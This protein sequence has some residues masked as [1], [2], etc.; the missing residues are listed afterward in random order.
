MENHLHHQFFSK[1]VTTTSC[2]HVI[3]AGL[4]SHQRG[5]SLLTLYAMQRLLKEACIN[6]EGLFSSF[7]NRLFNILSWSMTEF[8]VSVREMQEKYQV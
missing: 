3:F 1:Y 7:L 6:D 8:S 2:Y 4:I 5:F